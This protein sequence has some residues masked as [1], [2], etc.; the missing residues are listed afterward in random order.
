[1][2]RILR[3]EIFYKRFLRQKL[4]EYAY[5]RWSKSDRG[6]SDGYTILLPIPSDL[7]V[8]LSLALEIIKKQDLTHLKEVLIIPD[9]PSLPFEKFCTDITR[10]YNN[11][12]IR[13]V[14]LGLKDQLAWT[15][16]KGITTRHFTQLVRGID[17]TRTEY[18]IIHD[19]DAFLLPGDF[20]KTQ[21]E[22]CRNRGLA[23]FGVGFRRSMMREGRGTFINTWE[24]TFSVGW[25]KSFRPFMHK[26][27]SSVVKGRRQEFDTMLLPQYLTDANL[28]DWT[29]RYGDFLHFRYVIATYRNFLNGKRVLPNYGLKLFLIRILIDVFDISGWHY[30]H[31]PEHSEFLEGKFGLSDLQSHP[32]GLRHIHGFKETLRGIIHAKI[33]S[34]HQSEV[35][36]SRLVD[37]L[38]SMKVDPD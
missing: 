27:Q 16:T 37:L 1:L 25:A 7:P 35:L 38:R 22:A 21:Y 23:A 20:L 29:P 12:P 14:P 8:F 11:L 3:N 15:L 30:S 33:F 24:M 32:D 19:S 26:G 6:L 5:S 10:N 31:V 36:E 17:E 34:Q 13:F 28:I 18:A 4:I 2:E 9:W